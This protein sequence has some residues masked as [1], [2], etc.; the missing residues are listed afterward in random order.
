MVGQTKDVGFQIGV[1]KTLPFPVEQVWGLLTSASGVALWL[2]EGVELGRSKGDRYETAD[3]TRGEVR[4]FHECDR[5]RLTWHPAAWDHSTTVQVA[6]RA[7]ADDKTVLTFHQEWLS[8]AT[9]RERQRDH[10]R[11]VMANVL[12]AL[13]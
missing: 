12:A 13:D 5:V 4:S 6:V 7:V 3:G 11:T 10:W 9:E 1:S 8:D 2:G